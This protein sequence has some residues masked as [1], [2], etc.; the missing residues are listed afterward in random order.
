MI[1]P[2]LPPTEAA[3]LD[4]LRSLYILDTPPEERFDR[5]TRLAT[6]LFG[7][8]ISFVS[9]VDEDRVWYK[10]K[11][12]L[13]NADELPRHVTFCSHAILDP[14]KALVVSDAT[15][16]ERFHDN[17]LV[18]DDLKL[19]FYA[20]QP[21]LSPDGHP[22]GTFCIADTESHAF[23]DQQKTSPCATWPRWPRPN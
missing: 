22:L 3:R 17:P 2:P 4:A 7:V 6:E 15:R 23:S 11:Q 10:S 12:G 8:P 18:T 9:L 20:S 19:R 1:A 14:D 16:D 21:L 13:R 5:I